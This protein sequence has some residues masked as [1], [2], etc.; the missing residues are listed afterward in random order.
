[1][2]RITTDEQSQPQ[3]EAL[4]PAALAPFAEAR[5]VL[6]VA[7]WNG[8]PYNRPAPA[9]EIGRSAHLLRTLD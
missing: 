6:E 2:Y 9:A 8:A 4:P 7:P 5:T 1:V 3:V